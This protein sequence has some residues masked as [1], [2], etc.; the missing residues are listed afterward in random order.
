MPLLLGSPWE[1]AFDPSELRREKEARLLQRRELR[2]WMHTYAQPDQMLV[3]ADAVLTLQLARCS[4][5]LKWLKKQHM[6][7]VTE[8]RVKALEEAWQQGQMYVVWK[9]ARALGGTGV[10]RRRRLLWRA[11]A[12]AG[13]EEWK[14][15]LRL[16]GAEG[17]CLAS[18]APERVRPRLRFPADLGQRSGV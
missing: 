9:H 3:E 13:A 6:M 1:E 14:E 15:R 12:A 16:P 5:K 2:E 10:G 11:S 8:A 18:P 7:V 17:G 4:A